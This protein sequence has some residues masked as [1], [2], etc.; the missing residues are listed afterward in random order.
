[1]AR[2]RFEPTW[3]QR[4]IGSLVSRVRESDIVQSLVIPLLTP[5][6][7]SS[8]LARLGHPSLKP[9]VLVGAG[10]GARL[11]I[12]EMR[13][14]PSWG[15]EP[16]ALVDDELD[17]VG[18]R[19]SGLPVVGRT[20][21]LPRVVKRLQAEAV[22]IAI[23]SAPPSTIDRIT[24]I[25]RSTG[26]RVLIMPSIGGLLRGSPREGTSLWVQPDDVLGRPAVSMELERQRAFIDGKRVLITGAAGSIG[27][28]LTRQVADL[29]PA[30]IFAVD[31]NETGLFELQQVLQSRVA[32]QPVVASVTNA[33]RIEAVFDRFRPDIVFHA[34]AYKHVAMM[35]D[36]PQEAV[37]TNVAGTFRTVSAAAAARVSRFVLVSTDKAVRPTSVMGATKRVAELVVKS[38][39]DQSGLSACCVRF[40]NVLG[41]RGSVV[42]IFESQIEHGG[43]VT[44]TDPE[45][46]RYFMTI[47]EAASLVIE[48]GTLSDPNAIYMLDMGEQ[49]YIRDL[50]ERM[51]RLRGLE[52]ERDIAIVYTGL[53]PGEKL[54]EDLAL[55]W[56]ISAATAH[57][58]VFRLSDPGWPAEWIGE[59]V[60]RLESLAQDGHLAQVRKE[61]FRLIASDACE[62]VQAVVDP[63]E[64]DRVL[65]VTMAPIGPDA[66]AE[67]MA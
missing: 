7:F 14:N 11:M 55:E 29:S 1:M 64:E 44:I 48:A 35:E 50:A 20:T 28:E 42:P 49:I 63:I 37:T 5:G 26:A 15:H 12:R 18:S 53:K 34:A 33:R 56:E 13:R 9:T 60:T 46:M 52:P 51:I 67:F 2:A 36:H 54:R 57:A 16:I 8:H 32:F 4:G 65:A 23:P 6:G 59:S 10:E 25:A 43:P 17:K 41:S 39:A 19:I 22:V 27:Q 3:R 31:I 30:I 58:K 62:R 61:L 24:T 47:P 45:V 38:V 66:Y 21:D 40:G